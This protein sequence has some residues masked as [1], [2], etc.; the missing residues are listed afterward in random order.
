MSDTL[1]TILD[2]KVVK[3]S[4]LYDVSIILFHDDATASLQT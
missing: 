3:L 4:E 1:K 2:S